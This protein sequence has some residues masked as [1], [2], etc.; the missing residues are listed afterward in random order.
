MG[1]VKTDDELER[2]Y[3]LKARTFPSALMLGV[4]FDAEAALTEACLPPPLEQAETPGGL[5]FVAEYGDTN[6]GPG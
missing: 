2:Y 4:M 5:I 1:F 6:L 3:S